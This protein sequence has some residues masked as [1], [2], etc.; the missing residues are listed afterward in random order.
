MAAVRAAHLGKTVFHDPAVKVFADGGGDDL[1]EIN[2]FN[3]RP[4]S[5]F[6][7]P[8]AGLRVSN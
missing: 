2:V 5:L 4:W 3:Q 1:S 6:R 7:W 8:P